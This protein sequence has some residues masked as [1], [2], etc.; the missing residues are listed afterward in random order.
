MRLLELFWFFD[1]VLFF[2]CL[3]LG[4][5]AIIFMPLV[6]RNKSLTNIAKTTN[7]LLNCSGFLAILIPFAYN[8]F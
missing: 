4:M 1:L 8:T 2:E 5:I 7:I 3:I 6:Q